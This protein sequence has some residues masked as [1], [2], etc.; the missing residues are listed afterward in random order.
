MEQMRQR[1]SEDGERGTCGLC[2]EAAMS[3]RMPTLTCWS[4]LPFSEQRLNALAKPA[5]SFIIFLWPVFPGSCRT[6]TGSAP[7]LAYPEV[8][9][10]KNM[11]LLTSSSVPP[12]A[13]KASQHSTNG[14]H[15]SE[16]HALH[17]PGL[18]GCLSCSSRHLHVSQ[19][20]WGAIYLGRFPS[21]GGKVL[22]LASIQT[23]PSTSKAGKIFE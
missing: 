21:P 8:V 6:S 7:Y 2:R 17:S 5:T 12:C 1:Y 20:P 15:P 16:H 3:S 10:S 13:S 4:S 14:D 22:S 18:H 11:T 9:L 23:N 19:D